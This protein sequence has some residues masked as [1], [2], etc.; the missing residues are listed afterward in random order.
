V[1]IFIVGAVTKPAKINGCEIY[2]TARFFTVTGKH[3]SGTPPTV[4]PMAADRLEE[5]R[6]DIAQNQ[7]RPYGHKT[8]RAHESRNGDLVVT[9]PL[10]QAERETRLERALSGDLSDYRDDRSAAVHGVLQLLAR[11]HQGDREAMEE[12]FCSS[13]LCSDW[14]SKWDRLDEKELS[15]AIECWEENGRPKWEQSHKPETAFNFVRYSTIEPEAIRWLWPG[16]LAA[17]K[18]TML[19][20]EPG[21][22]KS[23]VSLD[24]AARITTGRPWPDGQPNNIRPSSVL[25]L[26]EEENPADTIL[27]RFIAAGG[28]RERLISLQSRDRLFRIEDDTERLRELLAKDA[29]DAKLIIFDPVIDYTGVQQTVDAEVRPVLNRL[30]KLAEHVGLSI[31]GINHLNKK[32]EMAATHRVAGARAWVS[33]AR[34]NFLL[35]KGETGMRHICPLKVNVAPDSNGSL[36][37]TIESQQFTGELLLIGSQPVVKW[38]GKGT[39]TLESI[40]EGRAPHRVDEV[41][42]WLQRA[43][44]PRGE[45]KR[46][47]QIQREARDVGFREKRVQRAATKLGVERRRTAEVPSRAEWRLASPDPVGTQVI[48]EVQQ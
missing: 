30:V 16:Y 41:V 36:D 34:L 39:A 42:E 32:T 19:N 46:A 29:P 11:K 20:G 14:G 35:G 45:W 18:L 27:P 26:T 38:H 13:E 21:H 6:D 47:E 2:S 23:V 43:L 10:S 48:Q 37:Y 3:I 1:H 33:V 31:L 24:I 5:L 28:D 44:E 22:G 17:R 40:L 15:K 7:L 4:N 8:G 25:L 9:K 12:E